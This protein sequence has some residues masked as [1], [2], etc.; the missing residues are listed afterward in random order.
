MIVVYGLKNFP[1]LTLVVHKNSK[2]YIFFPAH[3]FCIT[4]VDNW[5][6]YALW[7]VKFNKNLFSNHE[8]VAKRR[9]ELL[10]HYL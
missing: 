2:I 8:K 5:V 3:F 9:K 1:V 7:W 6:K 4:K 10:K